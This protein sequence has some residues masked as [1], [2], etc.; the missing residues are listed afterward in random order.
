MLRMKLKSQQE[1]WMFWKSF[2]LMFGIYLILGFWVKT[3]ISDWKM[4]KSLTDLSGGFLNELRNQ[5]IKT[6]I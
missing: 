4:E 3:Y 1:I 6:F 5:A 2:Q